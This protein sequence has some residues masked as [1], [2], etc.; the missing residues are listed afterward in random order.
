MSWVQVVT[1]MLLPAAAF[2]AAGRA[3][4]ALARVDAPTW[5][6]RAV[7]QPR[8]PTI[9]RLGADLR[10]LSREIDRLESSDVPAKMARMTATALAYDDVLLAACRALELPA[11]AAR[12]PLGPVERL[13]AEAALAREG[14]VW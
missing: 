1:L 9:E 12:A 7:P 8:G 3:W 5:P 2:W 6:G 10:R 4:E 14:M 11:P 13:Q